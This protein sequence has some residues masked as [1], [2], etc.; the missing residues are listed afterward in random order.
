MIRN[1]R[2]QNLELL[3]FGEGGVLIGSGLVDGLW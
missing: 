3:S 2:I 1:N